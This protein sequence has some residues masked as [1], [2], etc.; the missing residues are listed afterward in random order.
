MAALGNGCR[1]CEHL[2]G[3]YH[4]ASPKLHVEKG[5][6][7]S[8]VTEQQLSGPPVSSLSEA[9]CGVDHDT[10][11][12]GSQDMAQAGNRSVIVGGRGGMPRKQDRLARHP[13]GHQGCVAPTILGSPPIQASFDGSADRV[14]LFLNQIISHMDL[15][16]PLY[17]SQ[18][19][20]VVAIITVLQGEAVD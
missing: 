5:F 20:M 8:R 12:Q 13:C 4:L 19:A 16:S 17:P 9:L 15:Y 6:G 10:Q 1:H 7:R 11:R 18:W 14:S 2:A 3:W